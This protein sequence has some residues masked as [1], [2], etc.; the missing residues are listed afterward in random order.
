ME[1]PPSSA[2]ELMLV[3][4]ASNSSAPH[5]ETI[6]IEPIEKAQNLK[7]KSGE[8]KPA[9]DT[10]ETISENPD[11]QYAS[12]SASSVSVLVPTGPND[13]VKDHLDFEAGETRYRK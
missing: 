1:K 2:T 3:G 11:F 10:K 8:A 4:E 13:D 7:L 5:T 6:S 12:R 9:R